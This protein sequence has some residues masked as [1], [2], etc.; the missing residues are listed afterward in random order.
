MRRPYLELRPV[1]R[2]PQ[3]MQVCV[4]GAPSQPRSEACRAEE[5]EVHAIRRAR[6]SEID[7]IAGIL[8]AENRESTG[9][10]PQRTA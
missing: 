10:Y 3:H 4:C 8:E 2:Y 9:R 7:H 5:R 6:I 1:T